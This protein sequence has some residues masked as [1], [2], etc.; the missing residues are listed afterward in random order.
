MFCAVTDSLGTSVCATAGEW[1]LT[2]QKGPRLS[3][4]AGTEAPAPAFYP[5][6]HSSTPN[7][8]VKAVR[9]QPPPPPTPKPHFSTAPPPP[10]LPFLTV[11]SPPPSLH[12]LCVSPDPGPKAQQESL[13]MPLLCWRG[14]L[15]R[16]R[17]SIAPHLDPSTAED[18]PLL[19]GAYT[20]LPCQDCEKTFFFWQ[21]VMRLPRP[22]TAPG[23]LSSSI[24]A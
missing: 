21:V 6:L 8:R 19:S 17:G 1:E 22:L 16:E 4:C 12:V 24:F 18:E 2:F 11:S 7:D 20:R 3:L 9:H 14:S 10:S 23:Q 5:P 15:P 13:E